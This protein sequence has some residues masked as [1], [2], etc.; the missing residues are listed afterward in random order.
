MKETKKTYDGRITTVKKQS[1][2]KQ[3][4][5]TCRENGDENK[6]DYVQKRWNDEG[7]GKKRNRRHNQICFNDVKNKRDTSK[8][9]QMY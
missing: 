1:D 6:A 7:G 9:V 8:S 5:K 2:F 4:C 3:P